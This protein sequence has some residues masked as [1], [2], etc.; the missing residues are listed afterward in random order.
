[1]YPHRRAVNGPVEMLMLV[2][3]G[4]RTSVS[5]E[6]SNNFSESAVSCNVMV[7]AASFV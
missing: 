4:R 7:V 3:G 5:I 6:T 1:M 2:D